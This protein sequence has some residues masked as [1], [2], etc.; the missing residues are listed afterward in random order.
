LVNGLV[1]LAQPPRL[2]AK[3]SING[4]VIV[5]PLALNLVNALFPPTGDEAKNRCDDVKYRTD[6]LKLFDVQPD[7]LQ[8]IDNLLKQAVVLW[9][10]GQ[11]Y[12]DASGQNDA[13]NS[14]NDLGPISS[15]PV[16]YVH[17]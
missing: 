6:H 14:G 3:V 9:S 13:T 11:F 15:N 10:R 16:P 17:N 2:R 5:A 1:V 4:R 7:T 12:N 8:E